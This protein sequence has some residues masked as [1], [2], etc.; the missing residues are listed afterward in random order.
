M[1]ASTRSAGTAPLRD[2]C[3]FSALGAEALRPREEARRLSLERSAITL[4]RTWAEERRRELRAEGR[5]AAGGWPG[6]VR[7]A[8]LRVDRFLLDELPRQTVTDTEREVAARAA[9]ASARSEWRR[10]ADPE[11]L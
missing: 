5:L 11:A 7:E 1:K 4:G 3:S 6:T 10:N 8:R 9:Y 2:T